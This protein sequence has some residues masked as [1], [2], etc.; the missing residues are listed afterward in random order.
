MFLT[1]ENRKI[2]N[3]FCKVVLD[4]NKQNITPTIYGSLGLFLIIGE[5][6][7]IDDIDLLII[8]SFDIYKTIAI[9]QGFSID[10]DHPRELIGNSTYISFLDEKDIEI[11]IN[12]KLNKNLFSVDR[13][14][15][16]NLDIMDY[17]AIYT[18]GLDNIHRKRKKEK[19]DL[20]KIELIKNYLNK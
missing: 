18:N 3:I 5:D 6:G 11:L 9:K 12:K 2:Y 10:P 8:D 19:D 4:L 17:L 14:R 7:K 13:I 20:H 15:F 1:N 16:Y